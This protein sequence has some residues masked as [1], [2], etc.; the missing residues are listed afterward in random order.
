M[1]W[2]AWAMAGWMAGMGLACDDKN[3]VPPSVLK[4]QQQ[5]QIPATKAGPT[6]QEL[7]TGPKK[8]LRLGEFPLT[9]EVPR[10]WGIRSSQTGEFISVGGEATSGDISI[11]LVQQSQTLQPGG[12][13]A[14]F[15]AAKKEVQAKPHPINRVE[16]RPL[17]PAKVLEQRMISNR[18]VNG[19][20]PPEVWGD[21]ETSSASGAKVVTHAVLNPHLVQWTF[22]V[23]IPASEGKFS[24]RA[25]TFIG[26]ALSEY[27][28][29]KEFLEQMM[30]TLKYE[31]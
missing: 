17:G 2:C 24:V 23:F 19:K 31:E 18:F 26:L 5:A 28:R 21:V 6:T 22:T 4:A 8:T 29:D 13:E 16:L 30:K 1:K 27:E 7:L 14:T 10:S 15:E 3:D 12:P 20:P 9:L 25:L 11:Q